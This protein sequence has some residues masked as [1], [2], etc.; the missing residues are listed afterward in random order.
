M[1]SPG[2]ELPG[3]VAAAMRSPEAI[4]RASRSSFL[5]SFGVLPPERRAALTAIYAFCRVADDAADDAEAPRDGHA[6]LAFWRQEL[7]RAARGAPETPVGEAVACAIRQFHVGSAHLAAVLDGV[8]MDLDCAD[9][10]CAHF[11]TFDQ[12]LHYCDKVAGAVGLACL[13]VF[14]AFGAHAERYAVSL[15]RALQLSNIAR[16]LRADAELGRVYVPHSW[17]TAERV[18][19]SWLRGGG[20]A[21]EYAAGG[22]VDR[23]VARLVC[24]ARAQFADAAVELARCT[25]RAALVPAEIMRAVYAEVLER[26]AKGGGAAVLR[27][28]RARVPTWRKLWLAWQTRRRMR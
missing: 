3:G 2:A 10:D 6:R 24:E 14:G 4:A 23:I 27:G 19:A 5:V 13:P 15:G 22:G 7:D 8:A 12:L 11:A 26:V 21:A 20:P 17:F 25:D 28:R 9:L 18:E 1:N 16:D